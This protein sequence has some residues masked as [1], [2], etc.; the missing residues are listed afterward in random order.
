MRAGC[1]GPIDGALRGISL[2]VV[3]R[4]SM[5]KWVLGR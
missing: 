2:I 5:P 4:T 3:S 1:V